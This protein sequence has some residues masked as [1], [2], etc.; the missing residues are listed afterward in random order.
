MIAGPLQEADRERDD[1]PTVPV[2]VAGGSAQCPDPVAG[3]ADP[4]P[5]Q[6]RGAHVDETSLSAASWGGAPV[7]G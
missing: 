7:H 2:P 3:G 1:V 6:G 4:L 5:G